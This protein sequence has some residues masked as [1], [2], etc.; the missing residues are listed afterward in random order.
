MSEKYRCKKDFSVEKC[1]GDGFAIPN[2][3]EVILAGDIYELDESG[4]TIISGEIHLDNVKDGSWVELSRESFKELFE[5]VEG[6][7]E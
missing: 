2:E 7:N 4:S 1:D 3:Y 6:G 5:L